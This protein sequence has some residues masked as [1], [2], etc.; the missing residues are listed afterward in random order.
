MEFDDDGRLV[1]YYPFEREMGHTEFHSGLL[2][3]FSPDDAVDLL[4]LWQWWDQR[5]F[6]KIQAYLKKN[7]HNSLIEI[8]KRVLKVMHFS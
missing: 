4:S 3:F 6:S 7:Q 5:D 8:R 1:Q 2:I